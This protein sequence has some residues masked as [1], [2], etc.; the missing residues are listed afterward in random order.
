MTGMSIFL[1]LILIVLIASAVVFAYF[2]FFKKKYEILEVVDK[3][4]LEIKIV[5]SVSDVKENI[6]SDPLAA[7]QLFSV[8]HGILKEGGSDFVFSF[9]IIVTDEKIRFIVVVPK[10]LQSHI[11]SQIYAQYPLSQITV[12]E[13]YLKDISKFSSIKTGSLV[14]NK[15]EVL[16]ILTFKDFEVDPLSAITSSLS[17]VKANEGV[18]IQL[19]IKPVPDNWQIKGYEYISKVKKKESPSGFGSNPMDIFLNVIKI[20]FEIF[21]NAV[22]YILGVSRSSTQTTD[23][24]SQ[25][26]ALSQ[27]EE[28]MIKSIDMKITRMGFQSFVRV[29]SYANSEFDSTQNYNSCMATFKQFSRANLNGFVEFNTIDKVGFI[30]DFLSRKLYTKNAY[31][32]NTEELATIYHLPSSSVENPNIDWAPIKISDIPDNLPSKDCVKLARARYRSK[33]IEYGLKDG[34]DRLRHMYMI[35][36]TGS[37]KSSL[38]QTMVIQDILKGNGVGVV[39]PH[40]ELIN[41]ILE[42]IPDDRIE[43]V[44]LIDPADT[45]YPVGINI[46]ELEPGDNV[47]R[48]ASEIVNAFKS[49]FKD[50]WGPRLE[51]ILRNTVNAMLQVPGTTILGVKRLLTDDDYRK[52]ILSA[53][54]DVAIK[55]YFEREFA[56]FKANPKLVT[57]SIS[58]IQNKIGPFET[59]KIVRNIL[60]QRNSTIK[61]NE[62]MNQK[63]IV[64]INLSK[65]LVGEDV[66]NLFGSLVI[67]KIQAAILA[68]ASIPM[69]E[70]SPFYLYI[71]EF[72]NFTTDTF[73]SI[74]SES[75]KYGLGLYLTHQYVN[76]LSEEI[77]FA[78][79][80][81]VGTTVTFGLGP[82]DA[83]AMKE[84]FAPY[85]NEMDIQSLPRFHVINNI[86]VD[87]SVTKP[88]IGEIILPWETF[89]KTGNAQKCREA[90]RRKYGT[91]RLKVESLVEQWI[92]KKFKGLDYQTIAKKS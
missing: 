49:I 14:L 31:I 29:V 27:S 64:L 21:A 40:G 11:T 43:D 65:G 1:T 53:L 32:L 60:C 45:E 80:G 24:R 4:F 89:E 57:E 69:E 7:E 35:G 17:Q 36:K 78:I 54:T 16:P 58:P 25:I 42:Y 52:F 76:Q 23:K 56:A 41:A 75:R 61:L 15:N 20:I 10:V 33:I 81:N 9:E 44:V 90:S 2:A 82:T 39:D 62:M 28:G 74:L 77:K 83:I 8:I 79:R 26:T 50:S 12:I 46:M 55:D 59:I 48:N 13:D 34:N 87:G 70:R 19:L 5:K 22:L 84:V 92:V 72:Q 71:D 18:A 30:D 3:V 51:Y 68:R 6:Q 85:F 67:S 63:K 88:F 38:F 47:D 66:M 73:M 91:E 86:M 37:G